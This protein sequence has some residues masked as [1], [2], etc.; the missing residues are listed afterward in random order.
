MWAHPVMQLSGDDFAA[1]QPLLLL[2]GELLLNA[3][4]SMEA[5]VA[6]WQPFARVE[7]RHLVRHLVLPRGGSGGQ[8]Q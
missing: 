3:F 5:M 2:L 4:R 6:A 7:G 1:A 8:W